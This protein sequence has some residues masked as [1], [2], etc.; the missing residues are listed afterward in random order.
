[1]GSGDELRLRF[2]A[3]APPAPGFRRSFLLQV[4][5]WAKDQDANTAYSKS[6]IPLPFRA[7][8]QYGELAPDGAWIRESLTRPALRLLRPLTSSR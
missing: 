1:M 8:K 6:T 3:L 4:Q 7:M 2:P 5:G